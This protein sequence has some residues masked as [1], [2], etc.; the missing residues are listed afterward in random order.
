MPFQN[1]TVQ[2]LIIHEVHRRLDDRQVVNPTY[3]QQLLTLTQDAKDD[4]RDR[5]ISAVGSQSQSIKMTIKPVVAGCAVEIAHELIAVT[6]AEFIIQ[7]RLFADRLTESQLRRDLP[8]G[9]LV[10]F[11]GMAGNPQRRYVG[12]VKAEKHSG[13]R[14]AAAMTVQYFKDLFLTPQAKL[15]KIGIFVYTGPQPAGAL[16]N[17]WEATVYDSQMTTSN[18]EGAA[19]YFYEGF[20]G[21]AL[22]VNSARLTKRFFDETRD[23]IR[24]LPV[25]EERKT[26]LLSGLYTYLKVDQAPTVQVSAFSN[27]YLGHELADSYSHFMAD[28]EFPNNAVPKDLTDVQ[29]QLRRRRMTF[30]RSVQLTAPPDAFD[31]LVRVR[32]ID[33]E[34]D[35]PG[36]PRPTWTQITIR[37]RIREQE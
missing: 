15:Y 7:S 16:P 36:G 25:P 3:G 33:G 4:F 10:V 17:G 12:V 31:D 26:D 37:D 24:G 9:I 34:P 14:Q 8:G 2:R 35:Q 11:Q 29:S 21:C 27:Q 6:D 20:L 32:E 23:F 30:S 5:V 22:P 18:R 19:Q 13:F 1:L 28:R